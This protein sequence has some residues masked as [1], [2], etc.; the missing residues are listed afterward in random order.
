[1]NFN[2]A[3]IILAF[4]LSLGLHAGLVAVI[5]YTSASDQNGLDSSI[6][7]V[8]IIAQRSE[9]ENRSSNSKP[10]RPIAK[11]QNK[12]PNKPARRPVRLAI[13]A[14]SPRIA[15]DPSGPGVL[16]VHSV[17][18]ISAPKPPYPFLARQSGFEGTAILELTIAASGL[19][20][21]AEIVQSSGRKDCDLAA[22]KTILEEWKFSALGSTTNNL[23]W[24]QRVRVKYELAD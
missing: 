20:K 13:V 17:N 6:I 5:A 3:S 22:Q 21:N 15:N 8:E 2:L 4:S 9:S 14:D 10:Q 11:I 12:S 24:K 1:M 16:G 19:V 23:E 18:L 7:S